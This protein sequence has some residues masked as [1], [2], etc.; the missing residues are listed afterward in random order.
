[1][2]LHTNPATASLYIINPFSGQTILS[3]FSTHPPTSERIARL[4]ELA[5][6]RP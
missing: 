1:M 6:R 5:Q 2:H 4:K 3:W